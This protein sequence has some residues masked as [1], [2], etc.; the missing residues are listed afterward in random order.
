MRRSGLK[1][2]KSMLKIKY[3]LNIQNKNEL[4]EYLDNRN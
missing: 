1:E 3:L 2:G 4:R